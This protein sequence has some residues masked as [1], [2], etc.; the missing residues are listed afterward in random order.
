MSTFARVVFPI[1]VDRAFSYAVP[2]HLA[3]RL[4]VGMRVRCPFGR[5]NRTRSGYVVGLDDTCDYD[6]V[7]DIREI[8]DEKPL[9]DNHM[10]ELCSWLAGYYMATLGEA[11]EAALPSGVRHDAR[12]RTRTLVK[13][14]QNI[15]PELFAEE[16][17]GRARKRRQVLEAATDLEAPLPVEDLAMLVGTTAS[18]VRKM[19]DDGALEAE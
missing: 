15:Q 5:G 17:Y 6:K 18:T 10:M 9:V 12:G 2:D 16:H 4:V 8:L 11:L 13:L 1:P 3:D 14:N 7:K 19:I